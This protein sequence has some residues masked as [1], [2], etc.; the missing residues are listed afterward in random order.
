MSDTASTDRQREFYRA[1]EHDHLQV[2]DDDLYAKK[3]ASEL[4]AHAGI[5]PHHRV[6]EIGAGFGRFT[7]RLLEHCG[8]VVALDLSERVLEDLKSARDARGIPEERCRTL[9]ADVTNL[10]DDTGPFDFVVGF[11]ILHHLPDVPRAIASLSRL[12][13][14]G[15]RAVFLEPNRRNP[16]FLAQVMFCEDMTWHEEKGMFQLSAR[17]VETAF[18]DAGLRDRE[19]RRFGFFPP[20]IFNRFP[21]ARAAERR[22]EAS[23]VLR[24]ALPFLLLSAERP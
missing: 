22:I 5:E 24:P 12:V 1:R 20:Q 19:T 6:L 16:L 2:R 8:S 17:K 18:R 3:L 21:V 4:A 13:A 14:S 11:F 9:C 23:G 10:P 15:G 7:F